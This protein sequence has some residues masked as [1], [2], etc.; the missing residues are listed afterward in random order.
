MRVRHF[1]LGALCAASVK[2]KTTKPNFIIFQPDEMRAESLG[3]YGH[4]VSRT[5]NF[6]TAFMFIED[7]ERAFIDKLAKSLSKH[8]ADVD[9]NFNCNTVLHIPDNIDIFGEQNSP[10]LN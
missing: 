6:E 9:E 1:L 4:P 2:A 3:C 7:E 8:N 5:P 10:F